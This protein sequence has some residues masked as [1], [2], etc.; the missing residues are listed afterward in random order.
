MVTTKEIKVKLADN[1]IRHSIIDT[2]LKVVREYTAM[3]DKRFYEC[4]RV[5]IKTADALYYYLN[6]VKNSYYTTVPQNQELV[7]KADFYTWVLLDVYKKY[8]SEI[9]GKQKRNILRYIADFTRVKE[10]PIK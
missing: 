5:P 9:T 6:Y 2:A 7:A 1:N 10:Y 3:N 8:W 4:Q